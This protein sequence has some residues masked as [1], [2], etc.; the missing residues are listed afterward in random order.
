MP[1]SSD[2]EWGMSYIQ[3][4][5]EYLFDPDRGVETTWLEKW[6]NDR[7]G[8]GYISSA[9]LHQ[10]LFGVKPKTKR[11]QRTPPSVSVHPPDTVCKPLSTV[12]SYTSLTPP[13]PTFP[14]IPPSVPAP[15]SSSSMP[16][17]SPP[18]LAPFPRPPVTLRPDPYAPYLNDTVDTMMQPD[19]DS[20]PDLT[21]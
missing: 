14:P 20:E 12:S 17:S 10:Y 16:I 2:A 8:E 4:C 18:T 11:P 19:S 7:D 15:S 1:E 5:G 3:F 9:R 13:R 21:Q 6:I